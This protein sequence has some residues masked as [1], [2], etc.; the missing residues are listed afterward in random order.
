MLG[1]PLILGALGEEATPPIALLVT[2]ETAYL[3]LLATL[4]MEMASRGAGSISLQAIGRILR[5]VALNP[6][7]AS[8]AL[9]IAWAA[10]G[11]SMPA[12]VERLVALLAQ[13]AVPVSLFALGMALATFE[14]RGEARTTALI[15]V[16]KLALYPALALFLALVV[17]DL[18]P[19]WAATLFLFT[20]MPVGANAFVFASRYDKAVGSISAAVAVSSAIA[21]VSVTIML[22]AVRAMGL[23]SQP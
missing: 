9:G 18:P 2:V 13:A 21:V 3:W 14:V 5:D 7:V 12:V 19:I 15:C 8:V 6:V 23:A 1:I 16:L 4:Q 17:F 10:A 22:A 20:S 11:I